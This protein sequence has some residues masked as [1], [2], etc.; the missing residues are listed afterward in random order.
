MQPLNEPTL[1]A[2]EVFNEGTILICLYFTLLFSEIGPDPESKYTLG[3]AMIAVISFNILVNWLLLV[4]RLVTLVWNI[5]R[6]KIETFKK[7]PEHASKY[8]AADI[9]QLD[10]SKSA[11]DHKE[12]SV[13]E[14]SDFDDVNPADKSQ[15]ITHIPSPP[16]KSQNHFSRA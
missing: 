6:K 14:E 8:P 1:N 4:K 7:V 15:N 2:L 16:E 12:E 10:L 9:T 5:V 13:F 3:W 11:F